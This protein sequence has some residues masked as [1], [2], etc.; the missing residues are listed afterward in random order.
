MTAWEQQWAGDVA[1]A[2]PD[3]AEAAHNRAAAHVDAL[4]R[5]GYRIHYF[6]A[7]RESALNLRETVAALRLFDWTDADEH[8]LATA[9]PSYAALQDAAQHAQ[10]AVDT[11]PKRDELET[12]FEEN[13]TE[14][15]GAPQ[16]H[17]LSE[18][19]KQGNSVLQDCRQRFGAPPSDIPS[20]PGTPGPQVKH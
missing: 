19:L 14:S 6:A 3:L 5:D 8:A 9:D 12:Y 2:K 7:N 13:F 10:S 15:S 4:Q 11:D 16:I 17:D 1:T 18:A 20:T